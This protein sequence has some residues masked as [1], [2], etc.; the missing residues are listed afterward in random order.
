MMIVI[1]ILATVALP[2]FNGIQERAHITED[3]SNLR[4]IGIGTQTYLNDHDNVL[5][6]TTAGTW[7]AQLHPKYLPSWKIFQSPFDTRSPQENDA[8]APV[9]Y[10]LNGNSGIVGL[11][12][13]KVARPSVF[14]LFAPAQNANSTV[15]FS[16]TAASDV[17]VLRNASTP[18]ATALGGTHTKRQRINALFAD[19][20]SEGMTWTT[21]TQ[22]GTATPTDDANYRWDPTQPWP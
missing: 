9:S 10:G 4:Q 1:T 16:G 3:L 15:S 19:I 5:F 13:D 8:T 7:M 18:A 2:V 14:I 12:E 20:H 22:G 6:S 11:S 21:F 17:T